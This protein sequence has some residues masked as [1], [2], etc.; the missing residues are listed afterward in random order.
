MEERTI[1]CI[2]CP[3][4]CDIV[5]RGEGDAIS[6]MEGNLCKR[7][8]KYARDEFS[9]PARILATT[10]K[11]EGAE[12]PLLPVRSDRP[13]PRKLLMPCMR[14]IRNVRVKAPVARYRVIIPDILG[15]GAN[16]VATGEGR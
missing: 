14:E 16:M 11:L 4:G 10:V 8:E 3:S 2:V 7:G 12:S 1:T 9:H 13:V 5:V 15:T 6:H